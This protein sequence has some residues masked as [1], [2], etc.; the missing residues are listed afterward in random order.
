MAKCYEFLSEHRYV[1]S[2]T[3]DMGFRFCMCGWFVAARRREAFG[4][5]DNA[6]RLQGGKGLG[7]SIE[8]RLLSFFYK[9]APLPR[10]R[11]P[12]AHTNRKP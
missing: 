6:L 5:C 4:C 10:E 11:M 8:W 7:C 2:A 1:A 9:R 12:Y 3:G